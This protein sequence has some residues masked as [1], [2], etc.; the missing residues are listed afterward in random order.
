MD[1]KLHHEHSHHE[2]AHHEHTHHGHSHHEHVHHEHAHH[3]HAHHHDN[4]WLKAGL[5]LIWGLGLLILS[6]TGLNLP[7]LLY[8]TLTG[9][10][11]L[12]TFYLGKTVYQS[13]WEALKKGQWVT[14]SLYAISTLTIV[15][16]SLVSLFIPSLPLMFEA[17]P[18]VLGFWHLGEGIEHTLIGTIS[19]TLDVR[20]CIEP[21]VQLK[22][23]PEK[24]MSIHLLMPDDEINI[25]S[26]QVIPVDGILLTK[27]MLYTTR[28]DGSPYL[29]E[30]NPGANIK[31]G[32]QLVG[33]NNSLE[34]RVTQTYQNSYL[35]LIAQNIKKA[36]KEKAPIE[37]WT[38]RILYYFIPG[39]LAVAL[40]SGITIGSLFTPALAIQCI[41]SVLVSA[42]PCAL[43]L[44]TPLGVKIGM[45]KA[46]EQGIIFKNGKSLQGAADIDTVVFDLNGTLTEG[47][48]TVR[49]LS[50]SEPQLLHHI[51]LL[52]SHSDHPVAPIIQSYIEKLNPSKSEALKITSIDK[53]HHAGIK[54]I[55]DDQRWIIG[56]KDMLLANGITH[57]P[58]P[59]DDPQKGSIYIA[60]NESVIGQIAL[61]DPLRKDALATINQ[62]KKQGKTIYLC[63][64]AD[65]ITA[66][67]YAQKLGIAKEHIYANAAGV[68]TQGGEISKEF[69]IKELKRKGHKVAMVGDASND[70]TAIAAADMGIAVQSS[71]GDT[72]TQQQAGILVQKGLLFPIA[73]A[74]DTA[75]KTKA[76]IVQNLLISLSYNSLIT[77]VAAGLFVAL[78]FTLNPVV[79]VALMV[80][81]ST[82]ILANLYRFKQQKIIT[83]LDESA[84]LNE[85]ATSTRKM[86]STL[87][88]ASLTPTASVEPPAPTALS[89]FVPPPNNSMVGERENLSSPTP[90]CY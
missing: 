59:F 38:N 62:L 50:I 29:K 68:T 21:L 22:N 7:I 55:I 5:G 34:M 15:L 17:A 28:V 70:L 4:H 27:A 23:Y 41:V 31:A 45:H 87:G 66:E 88:P 35:S 77:L 18:L 32:M 42:C 76:N 16:V 78:G 3:E 14:T 43:S 30:F 2:H 39:L 85:R 67:H 12:M 73:A 75:H 8:Y 83:P 48:I 57:I 20:D 65:Q 84:I 80:L 9:L 81:E 24:R 58:A 86:I 61:T 37:Q 10:T 54:G 25:L 1:Y 69:Y 49:S 26:G 90:C 89:L 82:V 71:I 11:T 53:S 56:N 13:A 36:N 19:K 64:G 40:I 52:E 33:G 72:V 44:I 60:R 47:A 6:M 79:G 63:T 51:A 74:F 46:S